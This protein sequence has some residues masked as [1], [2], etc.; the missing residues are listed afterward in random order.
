ML[1]AFGELVRYRYLLRQLVIV[2]LKVRYK[3]SV[4]G[5]LWT[6]LNPLFMMLVFTVL[7]TI[8]LPQAAVPNF[9]LFVLVALLPWQ[10]FSNSVMM[11]TSSVLANAHLI[12]KVYFPREVLPL[13][14]VLANLVNFALA[15]VVLFG[16]MVVLKAPFTIWIVLLPLIIA[17]QLVFTLGWAF[18]LSTATIFYRDVP[19]IM[20]VLM[21]AWFFLT[22][23][24]YP[25]SILPQSKE[26]FGI[27]LNVQ[28]LAYI[29]NPMASLIASYRVILYSGAPPA[30]DFLLRTTVTAIAFLSAGYLF[31]SHFKRSMAEEV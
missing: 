15:L 8:M 12:K 23:I 16:M 13:S 19:M 28:R 29:L 26:I 9:P 5:F 10:F 17:V 27:V 31:F 6:F 18:F 11:S 25:M 1:K 21:L 4:L 24:F 2:S 30:W 7:F 14:T 22:P 20:D 3:N